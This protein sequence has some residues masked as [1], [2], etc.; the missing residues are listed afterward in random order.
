[1]LVKTLIELLSELDPEAHVFVGST[2]ADAMLDDVA[3][4]HDGA[5]RLLAGHDF[6]EKEMDHAWQDGHDEGY[7]DGKGEG[8]GKGY[9][10]GYDAAY[11]HGH[12]VG[13]KKATDD[14]Y[15][16]GYDRGFKDYPDHPYDSTP[17][18]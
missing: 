14:A 5:V 4:P 11:A 16:R 13:V 2:S 3:A 7:A 8:Y 10:D 9:D 12:K 17:E 18:D 6:I 1:M 15:R